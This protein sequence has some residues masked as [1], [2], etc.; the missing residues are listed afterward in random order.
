MAV[1]GCDVAWYHCPHL[2]WLF[3]PS[4]DAKLCLLEPV[5]KAG[6]GALY[7]ALQLLAGLELVFLSREGLLENA[8][9]QVALPRT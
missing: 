8:R 6:P 9:G 2:I 3:D 5:C 7:G 1:W 4:A